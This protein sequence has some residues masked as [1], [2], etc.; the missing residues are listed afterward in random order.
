MGMTVADHLAASLLAHDVR[1][2]FG[3]PSESFTTFMD[4][5]YGT[6]DLEFVQTRHEGGAAF[7]A[8]AHAAASGRTGVVLGG[9]APGAAN[10]SIGVHA[11]LENSTP[12]LVLVGQM[13]SVNRGREGFQETD[14]AAFLGPVAKYAVEESDPLRVPRA[15]TRALRLARSGRPGP[16]VL[17]LPEDVFGKYT[18]AEPARPARFPRPAPAQGDIAELHEM[19]AA[20]RRPLIVAGGGVKLSGAEPRLVEVAERWG[21]PVAAAWRRHDAFGNDHPRYVGHL[22]I[23]THP[24]VIRSVEEADLILAIGARLNENTTRGYTA[25]SPQASIAQIDIEASMIGKAYPAD[26]GIV[27][28]VDTALA[29]MLEQG[30]AGREPT[31]WAVQ[32]RA[33]YERV[34]TVPDEPHQDKVDNRQIIRMLREALPDE[35]ILTNDAGNFSGWLH[36]FFRFRRPHTYI[37]ASSGAMGYGLPAAIGAK[38]AN[39]D[40]PVVSLAGDGGFLM[41][42]SE[43][44]TAVRM[45]APVIAVVFNNNMFGSIRMHQERAYPGHQ[46]G[47]ALGNPDIVALAESFGAFGARVPTDA[48]FP[49]TFQL[50]LAQGRPAV[51]EIVSDPEQITVWRTIEQLWGDNG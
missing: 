26:L 49:A 34:G 51:I 6:A 14:L 31:E 9:R 50:A 2:V 8:E 28:D 36:T 37:G 4:S 7:M 11:A 46:I 12:L 1:R 29:A 43:L 20:A 45:N 16:V 30:P 22:G 25:I 41:T 40:Q 13:T 35:A 23:G 19:L 3:V 39:P 32:R 21:L 18:D 10:L 15:V 24:D 47:S 33:A 27:A 5:L 44:E 17:S 48:E 42:V 38:L